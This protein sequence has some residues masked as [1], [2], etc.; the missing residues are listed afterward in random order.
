M[1][2]RL[3]RQKNAFEDIFY[4]FDIAVTV[5]V[6]IT[7]IFWPHENTVLLGRN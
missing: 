3:L 4:G 5:K 7:V 2:L 6:T 1:H